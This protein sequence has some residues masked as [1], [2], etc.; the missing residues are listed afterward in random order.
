MI[1]AELVRGEWL[2]KWRCRECVA[3]QSHATLAIFHQHEKHG[4]AIHEMRLRENLIE[5]RTD[6]W[7]PRD[8]K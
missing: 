7:R 2:S 5:R 4:I 6:S 3:E 1:L 8:Q